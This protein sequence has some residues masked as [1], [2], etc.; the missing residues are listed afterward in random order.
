M[1]RSLS[2]A[3]AA[4][5]SLV[6][7]SARAQ[8]GDPLKVNV[9]VTPVAGGVSMI[10]GANGFAGGNVSVSVGDDGLFVID[11]E[12]AP[13]TPKLK[14]ALATLSKKPVRFVVNTHWHGDHTGGNP[15]LAAAGAVIVAQENVRSRL[16]VDQVRE[17]HGQKMTTAAL[18]P[19]ALPVVTFVEDVTLHLNGDEVHVIH[20]PP[21]HTD[22]DSIV[23]FKKANVIATGDVVVGYYPLVDTESGG[24]FAG[25]ITA[26]DKVLSLADDNTKI[27]PGHGPVMSKADVAAY[28]E[29][30]VQVRDRIGKLVATKKTVEEAKAAKPLADLDSRWGQGFVQADFVIEGLYK[31]PTPP[32]APEKKGKR[33][34]GK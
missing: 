11:D 23:Q 4:G 26:A 32:A 30:L 18:P 14:A 17:F 25:F 15:G 12:L 29:M 9:K 20:V 5:L 1:L 7:F 21:A 3:L 16:S 6:S 8:F 28:R 2:L 34:G 22:G 19:A 31:N 24:T 13:L 33:H 27:V 10:E